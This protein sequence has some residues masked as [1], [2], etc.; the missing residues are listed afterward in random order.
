MEKHTKATMDIED[1]LDEAD[2]AAAINDVR[3]TASEVFRRVRSR[4]NRE[5]DHR[6]H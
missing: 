4:F 5:N 3:Y 2:R 1:K 6:S